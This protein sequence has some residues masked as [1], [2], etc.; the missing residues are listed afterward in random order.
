[1]KSVTGVDPGA[2]GCAVQISSCRGYVRV[3]PFS[4]QR[5]ELC[6][7]RRFQE[8]ESLHVFLERVNSRPTD[9]P[10]SAFKF[11]SNFGFVR[12][13]LLAV[14]GG[15]EFVEPKTWQFEFGLGGKHAPLG[16]TASQEYAARKRAHKAKAQELF[17]D[18]KVTLEIAD[19]LL[20]AEYGYRS[21]NERLT[22]GKTSE[23]KRPARGLLGER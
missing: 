20:I 8:L 18:I 6:I 1:M 7:L 23:A 3:A 22:G 15:Y 13:V 2:S 11:G 16:S 5:D 9:D 17:P 12:G 19:A 4:K 14:F 10:Y 21:V